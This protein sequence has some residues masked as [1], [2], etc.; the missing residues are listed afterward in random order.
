MG[1]QGRRVQSA[2]RMNQALGQL[3]EAFIDDN[4]VVNDSKQQVIGL[5]EE[6]RTAWKPREARP[7]P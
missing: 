2:R 7:P 3:K 6:D 1:S 5:I 4:L